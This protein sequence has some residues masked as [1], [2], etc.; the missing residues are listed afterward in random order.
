MRTFATLENRAGRDLGLHSKGTRA[1]ILMP[2][3][4]NLRTIL[5]QADLHDEDRGLILSCILGFAAC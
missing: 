3:E 4:I 5:D 1:I 2:N